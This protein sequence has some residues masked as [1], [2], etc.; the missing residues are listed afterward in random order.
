LGVGIAPGETIFALGRSVVIVAADIIRDLN[1]WR[2]ITGK[3]KA[4]K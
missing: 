2:F 3:S 4:R 1:L